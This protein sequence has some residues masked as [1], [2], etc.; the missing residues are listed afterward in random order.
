MTF[1]Y[2]TSDMVLGLKGQR[3]IR[4]GFK[5]SEYLLV[6]IIIIFIFFIIII[7]IIIVCCLLCL[8]EGG[9]EATA[10]V[11]STIRPQ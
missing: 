5:L 4:R 2:L 6:F 3:S 9:S 11:L 10:A 8:T 1:G 7:I